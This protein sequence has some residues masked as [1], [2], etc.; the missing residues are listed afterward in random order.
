MADDHPL[1]ALLKKL[2]PEGRLGVELMRRILRVV[3]SYF[4]RNV[5]V[6]AMLTSSKLDPETKKEHLQRRSEVEHYLNYHIR[7]S[8]E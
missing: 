4:L 3:V 1:Y 7:N 8:S 2:D 5:C 6:S